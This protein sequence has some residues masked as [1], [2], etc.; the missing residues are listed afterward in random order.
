M[1]AVGAWLQRNYEVRRA[2]ISHLS[3][4]GVLIFGYPDL[5]SIVTMELIELCDV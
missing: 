2:Y 4:S 1:L 3:S 5:L